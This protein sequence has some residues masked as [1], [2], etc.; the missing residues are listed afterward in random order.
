MDDQVFVPAYPDGVYGAVPAIGAIAL[1]NLVVFVWLRAYRSSSP[2]QLLADTAWCVPSF[3]ML[4]ALACAGFTGHLAIPLRYLA[5]NTCII[6][7]SGTLALIRRLVLSAL[8]RAERREAQMACALRD[9]LVLVAVTVLSFFMLEIPWNTL[10]F[11]LKLSYV[12]INLV[13]IV[14]PYI[15]LYVI[16]NRRG[17]VLLIPLAAYAVMGI[18]QFFVAEFKSSA[19]LPSDLLA[20]GTALSVSGGYSFVLSVQPLIALSLAAV[21]VSLLSLMRPMPR[22]AE[23][24]KRPRVLLTSARIVA[25]CVMIA[26]VGGVV[27]HRESLSRFRAAGIVLG[28]AGRL[29][30]SGLCRLLCVAYPERAD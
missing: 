6:V 28:C 27:S 29:S 2:R 14:I 9:G 3:G 15:I 22:P 21:T 13:L 17:S 25:G 7:A 24:G 4:V 11:E 19:I 5:L 12:T 8:E 1:A 30:Q 26:L 20:L 10:L 23:L 16:G 18:A